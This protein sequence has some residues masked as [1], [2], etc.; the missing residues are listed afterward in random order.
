M[1][2]FRMRVRGSVGWSGCGA[3]HCIGTLPDVC[4]RNAAASS[5]RAW[6]IVGLS[7]LSGAGSILVC[8]SDSFV[9]V[10]M[11]VFS[12]GLL[13][14]LF[15][16]TRVKILSPASDTLIFGGS[17]SHIIGSTCTAPCLNCIDCLLQEIREACK[18]TELAINQSPQKNAELPQEPKTECE[19]HP[20]LALP[21]M[22]R[23]TRA[24][25]WGTP[26]P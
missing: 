15:T 19:P 14:A 22:I 16:L 2:L 3:L 13:L 7:R 10:P 25:S 17:H 26:A 4:R 6:C 20:A 5:F 12:S 9:R 8:L 18:G 11:A 24:A 23:R 1:V 21:F